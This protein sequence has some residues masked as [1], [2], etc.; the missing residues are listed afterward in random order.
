MS[1]SY[2]INVMVDLNGALEFPIYCSNDAT[3]YV[4]SINLL[5][6]E[7]MPADAVNYTTIEIQDKAENMSMSEGADQLFQ[8][9]SG[10]VGTRLP[11][12]V[13]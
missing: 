12:R 2:E 10:L 9:S 6:G 13:L 4:D 5:P 3:V 11:S 1:L 8:A 7:D